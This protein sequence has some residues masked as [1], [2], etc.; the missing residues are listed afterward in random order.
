MKLAITTIALG[1]AASGWGLAAPKPVAT[2]RKPAP[3]TTR[4]WDGP[5]FFTAASPSDCAGKP[6][7]DAEGSD[8]QVLTYPE[9]SPPGFRCPG[10]C[11]NRE[12]VAIRN[13]VV[14]FSVVWIDDDE[15]WSKRTPIKLRAHRTRYAIPL[16]PDGNGVG[17]VVKQTTE[18]RTFRSE[19][20]PANGTQSYEQTAVLARFNV[21][22]DPHVGIGRFGVI[23]VFAGTKE[24]LAQVDDGGC[25]LAVFAK[26]FQPGDGGGDADEGG[27]GDGDGGGTSAA[28]A[29]G[30]SRRC[31]QQCK[32]QAGQCRTSCRGA[33]CANDCGHA[34]RDCK[35]G[36]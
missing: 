36:C 22:K 23:T 27:D 21:S 30:S 34:E 8:D 5:Y 14:T 9:W 35:A 12:P 18:P 4:A 13:G 31:V 1:L 15:H 17:G 32:Q 16:G 11:T 29:G 20:A 10:T 25:E 33:K 3:T 26:G 24:R 2:P 28:G 6:A 19:S 7:F